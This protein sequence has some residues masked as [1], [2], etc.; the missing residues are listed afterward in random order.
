MPNTRNTSVGRGLRMASAGAGVVGS[1]LGYALQRAFLGEAE[2]EA[3]LKATHRRAARR[4]AEEMKSLRGAA[5]K[6]GQTRSLQTGSLPDETLAEFA[7]LQM[8][9]P[10]MHPSL[11]RV[12]FRRSMGAEPEDI[13]KEFAP[14]P[15]AAASLGQVH[16]AVTRE[17]ERVAVKIQYPGIRESIENDFKV[18]RTVIRAAQTTGHVPAAAIDEVE[19]QVLAETDYEQEGRNM[20]F[21][22]KRLAT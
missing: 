17:G 2:G 13:F 10:P 14:E 21:F 9:A 15:F 3:K 11:A 6:I 5:M 18:F 8:N 7:S 20:E 16:K 4:V 12:Q 1:Y 22:R 19:Q